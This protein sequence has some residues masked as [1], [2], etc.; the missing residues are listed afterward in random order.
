MPASTRQQLIESVHQ[1]HMGVEKKQYVEQKA[2]F[3]PGMAKQITSY[4]AQ[5]AVRQKHRYSNE[6][7]HLMSHGV[8]DRQRQ[9]IAAD[10]FSFDRK[11]YLVT[12]DYYIRYFEVD[13]LP[14]T[15]SKL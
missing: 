2:L 8:P 12:V 1:G 14:N 3:W 13:A 4:I 7:E 11:D 15:L 5:C 10:L 6:K 9:N